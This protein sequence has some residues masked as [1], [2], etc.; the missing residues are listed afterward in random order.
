MSY[1]IETRRLT[2][3]FGGG[4]G[5][6]DLNLR[7]PRGTVFGFL[8]PNGAGKTTTLRLL[9]GFLKADSGAARILGQPL[10]A[11]RA[12]LHRYI[13]YVPG[14]LAL[15]SSERVSVYL[16][17]VARMQGLTDLRRQTELCQM[18]SV[19][20]DLRIRELS[21]GNRQKVVLVQALQ[22]N[23][24]LLLLDEPTDGLDPVLRRRVADMLRAHAKRGGTVF[25]SSH[26]VH[27][28]Q[29]LCD[30]VAIVVE[31]R[32]GHQAKVADLMA[33]LPLRV[34]FTLD[35]FRVAQLREAVVRHPNATM[36]AVGSRVRLD[37]RGD[38][39]PLMLL[40][41]RHRARNLNFEDKD[42]EETFMKLY[43]TQGGR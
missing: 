35:S 13:G 11:D 22:H 14:E 8:G 16:S 18:L 7:V 38:P 17:R 31:G 4:R 20:R 28:I 37:V 15:P 19:P 6:L 3:D 2:K 32:L 41:A 24:P 1:A 36:R 42:L 34:E 40:L 21:K 23:P 39:L 29:T 43:N 9:M 27:E 5:I 12:V 25:L 10:E 30:E 33:A 26:I